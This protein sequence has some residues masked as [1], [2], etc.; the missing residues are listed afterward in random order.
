MQ[1]SPFAGLA[2]AAAAASLL[3]PDHGWGERA[4]WRDSAPSP[5]PM[6]AKRMKAKRK[7][8]A[9]RQARKATRAHR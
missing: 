8:Q 7:R 1:R 4:R 2:M 6:T 3:S 5:K 9:Q